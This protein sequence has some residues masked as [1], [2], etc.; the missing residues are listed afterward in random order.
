MSYR[1]AGSRP[2]RYITEMKNTLCAVCLLLAPIL[3]FSQGKY[4]KLIADGKY[5]A[6]NKK[7]EKKLS[8][9]PLALDCAYSKVILY[10]TREFEKYSTEMA[11]STLE[12][13]KSQFEKLPQNDK[14]KYENEGLTLLALIALSKQVIN[15]AYSDVLKSNEI[16]DYEQFLLFY[17]NADEGIKDQINDKI[18]SLA[19]QLAK[20]KNTVDAYESFMS[21]YPTAPQKKTAIGMRNQAAFDDAKIEN[22]SQAFKVFIHT[23]PEANQVDQAWQYIYKMDFNLLSSSTN[24]RDFQNYMDDYPESPFNTVAAEKFDLYLYQEKTASGQLNDYIAFIRN[25]KQN[26]HLNDAIRKALE[27]GDQSTDFLVLKYVAEDLGAYGSISKVVHSMYK[28]IAMDGRSS[29]L[30]KFFMEYDEYIDYFQYEKDIELAYRFDNLDL[31]NITGKNYAKIDAFIQDAA[32]K[33][34]A[35]T[36]LTEIARSAID[37]ENWSEAVKVFGKYKSKFT[38]LKQYEKTLILL[39]EKILDDCKKEPISAKMNSENGNEYVP[40]MTADGSKLYFCGQDRYD[41]LGGEDIFVSEHDGFDWS[42]PELIDDLS[43]SME[44]EAPESVTIDGTKMTIFVE[45]KL[46]ET[47][48]T[49]YGWSEP[50][51]MGD[52]M[53][54]GDWNADVCYTGD[55]KA[56]LFTSMRD[57]GYNYVNTHDYTGLHPV[58]IYVSLKDESGEWMEPINLGPVIN[59]M[60]SERTPFLHPDMK[61]LYFSSNGHGGLGSLDVYMSKRLNEESWTEWSEPVNIGKYF[62]TSGSNWGYKITTDGKV[63]YFSEEKSSKDDNQ[64]LLWLKLPPRLRP[65]LVATVSGSLKDRDDKPVGARLLIEDLVSGNTVAEA[66]SDPT[67]GE[68]FVV[69]PLGKIYGYHVDKKELFP[70]SGN[71]DL[72]ETSDAVEKLD[73]IKILTFDEMIEEG[74]SVPVNNLFF[75]FGESKLLPTSEPELKRIAKILIHK[76]LRISIEGHTDNVGSNDF[77]NDLSLKRSNAVK[78]FLISEGCR[79]DQLETTG[80]GASKPV[81]SNETDEGRALNRRVE[82]RFIK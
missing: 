40:V 58:D 26:R 82:L 8:Q 37:T 29:Y 33:H 20:D 72:R 6:A 61:T 9:D 21:K 45:G 2:I 5:S 42:Y 4:D 47:T 56:A 51:L 55:G 13:L 69:L 44:N 64:D 23:Y 73:N 25:Y 31:T 18:Y 41:N 46:Y 12:N 48:K 36:A 78:R 34:I 59:T 66:N 14:E 38:G 28:I 17:S 10:N 22:T 81:A 57:G 67:N 70:V 62:N 16:K 52:N 3:A 1:T 75:D 74:L 39:E 24:Y 71:I 27:V 11:Y 32:P 43:S 76:N 49:T 30:E 53:N 79:P 15:N 68:F 63:A 7:I 77:N 65:E 80:F 54:E 50:D 35:L 60:Y 19:F